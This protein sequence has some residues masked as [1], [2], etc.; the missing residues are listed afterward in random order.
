MSDGLRWE[1]VAALV[2]G[3]RIERLGIGLRMPLYY[4]GFSTES[5]LRAHLLPYLVPLKSERALAFELAERPELQSVVGLV[6]GKIPSRATL[7]HFRRR[8]LAHFR[9][10]MLRSLAVMTVEADRLGVRLPFFAGAAPIPFDSNSEDVY[11]DLETGTT[12]TLQTAPVRPRKIGVYTALL[13]PG[14][15]NCDEEDR[16]EKTWLHEALDFPISVQWGLDSKSATRYLVQPPWLN[17][18]YEAKDL[19][20]YFGHG[21]KD[22]YTACNVLV[23]RNVNG[24]DEILLTRR[25]LG[26]GVGTYA[27]P[28]GKKFPDESIVAC[29]KRELHEEVGIEYRD[30]RP[31]SWRTTRKPGFPPVESVGVVATEWRGTPRRREHLAHSQ[32]NWYKLTDLPSPLFFPTQMAI[33]DFLSNSFA[34]LDWVSIEPDVPLAL[35]SE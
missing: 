10:L 24:C 26:S 18:P 27:V 19:G 9:S 33:E 2:R 12:I 16:S 23:V 31:I 7:W 6:I 34:G 15:E 32:W 13:L 29:V 4:A 1:T 17:S 25:L 3:I 20:R 28:G 5:L 21:G 35:W 8:N 11:H 30:G 14:F 22:P